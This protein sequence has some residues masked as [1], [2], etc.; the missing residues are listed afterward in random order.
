MILPCIAAKLS[1]I[2]SL[3][4]S[5]IILHGFTLEAT[6]SNTWSRAAENDFSRQLYLST[7]L[8]LG[9][10]VLAKTLCMSFLSVCVIQVYLGMVLEI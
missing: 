2:R 1:Y 6:L 5:A 4:T 8:F 9:N 7:A 10:V 3:M